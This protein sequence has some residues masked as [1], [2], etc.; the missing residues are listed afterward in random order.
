MD[1]F[2]DAVFKTIAKY[3]LLSRGEKVVVALSGGADSVALLLALLELRARLD[4]TVEAAHVNH[5]LRSIESDQDEDFVRSLCA[6]AGVRLHVRQIETRQQAAECRQ[7]LEEYARRL[8]YDFLLSV[9]AEGG[10][11]VATGHT[12]NDLSETFLLK[13]IRGA[14]ISGLSGVYPRRR[15]QLEDGATV[16]VVR[17]LLD[18]SRTEI[19]EYL[20]RRKQ[21]FREDSSNRDLTFDRNLVRHELIPLLKEKF[22][23][24]I[25]GTLGRTALLFR[26][27]EDFLSPVLD[28]A[29]QRCRE[30][31]DIS[32]PTVSQA[33][34]ALRIPELLSQHPFVQKEIVRR[35][36]KEYR[37]DLRDVTY[38]H[39]EDV[40]KIA[41]GESGCECHLGKGVRVRR[42]FDL[43][44]FRGETTE[45]R[46]EYELS[47]P[48]DVYI[49]EVSKRVTGRLLA[50]PA[51]CASPGRNVI[52]LSFAGSHLRVRNRRAGDR[53]RIGARTRKLKEI[54]IEK[55]IPRS[56]RDELL[57]LD[58]GRE[59]LWVEGFAPDPDFRVGP[60]SETVLE[61]RVEHETFP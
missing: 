38:R 30:T 53:Y 23:P 31:P 2:E 19:L 41:T 59:I 35:A 10:A 47:V 56:L 36:L 33:T 49:N 7:N 22:N 27:M 43:L 26:E 46:F 4:L 57:V 39:V 28:E 50:G 61:I 45:V 48:G 52:L 25:S 42:E 51:A 54:L 20:D 3:R 13:L 17:P 24:G 1:S 12:L 15:N 40:L 11:T 18:S 32:Q 21:S 55:K 37:G 8:R 6:G 9:A 16:D 14:G 29:Y 5:L 44:K 58:D 60:G 34:V